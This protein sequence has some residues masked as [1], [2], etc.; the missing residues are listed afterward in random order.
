ML[1]VVLFFP[2]ANC[3]IRKEM[4]SKTET[5][6]AALMSTTEGESPQT[7]VLPRS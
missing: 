2:L 1:I 7:D 5:T 6:A 3:R 4:L